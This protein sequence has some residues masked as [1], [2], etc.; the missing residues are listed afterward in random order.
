MV[1]KFNMSEPSKFFILEKSG[2]IRIIS[3][4]NFTPV[5]SL[6]HCYGCKDPSLDVDWSATNPTHVAVALGG[7]IQHWNL[8][9][10]RYHSQELFHY[11]MNS[12]EI[13]E[14]HQKTFQI[15]LIELL[16]ELSSTILET[17]IQS[18]INA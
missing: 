4:T 5:T 18:L 9:C 8:N 16:Q 13:K 2:L 14:K 7:R 10:M 17:P 6:S 11:L 15:I 3:T 12:E 1:V